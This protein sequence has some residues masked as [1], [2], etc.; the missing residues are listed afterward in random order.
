MGVTWT[1][2]DDGTLV[3]SGTGEMASY[4]MYDYQR[5][6]YRVVIEEGVTYIGANAFNDCINLVS[7]S[8]PDSVTSIYTDAFAGC[9]S[10][11]RLVI[12]ESVRS[13]GFGALRDCNS[14]EYLAILNSGYSIADNSTVIRHYQ[15]D[16]M[17]MTET[18]IGYTLGVPGTTTV[19]SAENS[20]V[21]FKAQEN[22]FDFEAI[23]GTEIP[24]VFLIEDPVNAVAQNDDAETAAN[25]DSFISIADSE[26]G[27]TGNL[28]HAILIL[29]PVVLLV[30]FAV[31]VFLKAKKAK[32]GG[33]LIGVTVI[34]CENCGAKLKPEDKF[35]PKCGQRL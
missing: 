6:I 18:A 20:V 29:I 24:D 15:V 25:G 21:Q 22:G 33:S 12:P 35:C 2:E 4:Y 17:D 1:L 16:G 28:S 26:E 27:K 19:Y 11:K 13:I 7:V 14:L 31:I 9:T 5:E 10:L 3:I 8:I 34:F 30:V 32:T 23:T